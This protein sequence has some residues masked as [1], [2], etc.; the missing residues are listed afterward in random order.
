[1]GKGSKPT[2]GF[3][4]HVAYHHGLTIGPIDAFLEFRGGD[5]TAWQGELTAS[6]TININAPMLWGGEKD[7]GGIVGPVDVMFGE[8]DQLPNPYLVQAF[9]NQTAAWRGFTTL[10]FKGGR[11]G[12]MNPY[13]KPPSYKIRRILQG[14]DNDT[15]WYPER[16][17]IRSGAGIPAAFSGWRYKVVSTLD[18]TDYSDPSVDDS[19]WSFGASPFG[20]GAYNANAAAAGFSPVAATVIPLENKVWLR[21]RILLQSVPDAFLF[22]SFVDN[23]IKCWINGTLAV[24]FSTT[25][26]AAHSE[27]LPGSLFAVGY[28]DIAVMG[29][30]DVNG[31]PAGDRFYFDL[32]LVN[33]AG[34]LISANPA[35]VL[36]ESRTNSDMGRESATSINDA[37]LRVAA[38]KL[39]AE[40][41]GICPDW[42][43]SSES[44]EEFEKRICKLIGGSFTRSL[45]DGQWY[46]DLARGDY[47]LADLPILT[48][49]DILDFKE[50]PAILDNAVNSVSVR[51]FDPERKETIVTAPTRALGLVAAFGTIHQTT[52]YRAIPTAELA[53][54][55]AERDVMAS[56]TPKRVFDLVTMR[57]TYAWRPNQYFRLQAPKRGIADMVCL[58]GDKQSGTLKSG[59]IRMR[60]VQDIYGLPS[61]GYVQVEPGVDTRPPQT[62]TPITAERALEAPYV[63]IA[64]MLSRA[65]LAALPAEVGYAM[66]VAVNPGGNL[67]YTMM[68]ADVSGAYVDAGRGEWCPTAVVVESAGYLDTHFTLAGGARLDAVTVGMG[69]LWDDEIARVDA[70]DVGA[71]TISLGRGCADTVPQPHTPGSRLWIYPA[72]FVYSATEYTGGEAI[73]VKLLANTGSQQQ[74]LAD[75][76]ALPIAF[77]QRQARPYPPGKLTIAGVAYPDAVPDPFTVAW[78]HRDRILQADQLIDSTMPDVGPEAGV[79]YTLRVYLDGVLDSTTTGITGTSASPTVTAPGM[80]RVEVT[81]VRDG[82]ESWQALAAVFSYG[83]FERATEDGG[84]RIT[85]SGD[86]RTLE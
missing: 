45:E 74:D 21:T 68:V 30:D 9:G 5:K 14:W 78:A 77:V 12:A 76:A 64:A 83:A 73:S 84:T 60:A 3:W 31:A 10:A 57:K 79:T 51:Y 52:D 65:D 80:V 69:V 81:A 8:P 22:D 23:G 85:E 15:A 71:G 11:Y 24:D 56:A 55:I 28:N 59:A 86:T 26:G 16:A 70:I 40:G 67:D 6:G 66:A 62:P 37:S 18:A 7:Q 58:V 82:L 34:S 25:L 2:I 75:V 43:P 47:V 41:F 50:Q 36:Y 42:D 1:M 35:H 13:P 48:D 20:D 32:R 33:Q 63:E 4:Y 27:M 72:G 53:S 46:L 54:R 19:S 49:D 39:Y 44:V 38:D 61:T 17:Q 29:Y